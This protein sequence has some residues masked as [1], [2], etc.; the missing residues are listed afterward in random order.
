MG[1]ADMGKKEP[2]P[3]RRAKAKA[4]VSMARSSSSGASAVAAVSAAG[5]HSSPFAS[6]RARSCHGASAV[7][8]A[9]AGAA[10]EEW[11]V[12]RAKGARTSFAQPSHV[13]K[14]PLHKPF[15]YDGKT[16]SEQESLGL[17]PAEALSA[18]VRGFIAR[19]RAHGIEPIGPLGDFSGSGESILY[20][21][22]GVIVDG[23]CRHGMFYVERVVACRRKSSGSVGMEAGKPKGKGRGARGKGQRHTHRKRGAADELEYLVKWRGFAG[24]DNSWEPAET[25]SNEVR[26]E[27]HREKGL[28]R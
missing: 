8:E 27:W 16:L 22:A 12:V 4:M 5:Q 11:A 10:A 21:R 25:L 18:K 26:E 9:T 7:A 13:C 28:P 20:S 2:R 6:P 24:R 3:T 15:P 1:Y 17:R 23:E 19:A 14:P